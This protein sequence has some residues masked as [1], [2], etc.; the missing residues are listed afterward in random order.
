MVIQE[1]SSLINIESLISNALIPCIISIIGIMLSAY[2]AKRISEKR[3]KQETTV[4]LI[5]EYNSFEFTTH[6]READNLLKN[7]IHM[8]LKELRNKYPKECVS[9]DL[10]LRFYT[11]LNYFTRKGMIINKDICNEFSDNFYHFFYF[12][13]R[14][15]IPNDWEAFEKLQ[16]LG[17]WFKKQLKIEEHTD[18]MDNKKE[19][20]EIFLKS[21]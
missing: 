12:H 5:S 4:N 1:L 18:L 16:N 19:K 6:R 8:G 9:V 20:R 21:K 11:R 14:E 15:S 3:N 7:N 2:I 13:F 17:Y 10:I